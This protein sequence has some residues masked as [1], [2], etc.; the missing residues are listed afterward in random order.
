LADLI[1]GVLIAA[2]TDVNWWVFVG[3]SNVVEK[4]ECCNV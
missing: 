1:D 2:I 3:V 4:F